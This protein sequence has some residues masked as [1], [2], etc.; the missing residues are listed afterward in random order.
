MNGR[1]SAYRPTTTTAPRRC[2]STARS[3]PPPRKSGS[4]GSG[5]IRRSRSTRPLRAR[6]GRASRYDDLSRRRV[7]RQAVPE[8]R[9]AARDLPRVRAAGPAQLLVGDAGV[10]QGKAVHEAAARGASGASSAKATCRS[11]FPSITCRTPPARSIPSPFDDAA[12][13]TVDGVGE[14]ATTTIGHGRGQGHHD[15]PRAGVSALG[16]AAVLGVHLLHG[17]QGQQRR[18]Q[19]DGPGAVRQP[20]RAAD[21]GVRARRSC[22]ELVDIREDGSILLNM[23]YFDYAT[24]L[25]MVERGEVGA[26]VRRSARA[27]RSRRSRRST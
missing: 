18:V 4:R 13:V 24:G 1:F 17:L 12:I 25:K 3:W 26:A 11:S 7:L 10:D 5:T 23:D 21:E 20:G 16:R 14:W 15:S 19:A 9:A 2:W 27:S 6:G 8:V 22:R